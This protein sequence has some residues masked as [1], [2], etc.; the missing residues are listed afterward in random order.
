M[1]AIGV[2]ALKEEISWREAARQ[3]DFKTHRSVSNHM[4][5]HWQSEA[6][7]SRAVADDELVAAI[8][9]AERGLLDAAAVS[10]AQ[11]RALYLTAAKNL[12]GLMDTQPSQ[13]NLIAALKAAQEI[14]G[15]KTQHQLLIAAG[16]AM[17]A[18]KAAAELPQ[19]TT[20]REVPVIPA[21]ALVAVE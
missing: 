11:V 7:K 21:P 10:P 12:R 17:F 9:D 3:L 13:G 20:G 5:N 14:T 16:E 18:R 2:Q 15:M 19:E 4:L 1:E 6:Q 8:V